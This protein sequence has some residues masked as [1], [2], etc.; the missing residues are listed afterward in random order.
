[1]REEHFSEESVL[2]QFEEAYPTSS[3]TPVRNWIAGSFF[4]VAY[5][6]GGNIT[7]FIIIYTLWVNP[8]CFYSIL[9]LKET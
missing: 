9:H 3:Y 2:D 7:T 4:L 8:G 6:L 5:Q 1:M